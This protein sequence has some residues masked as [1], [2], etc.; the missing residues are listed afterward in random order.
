MTRYSNGELV[1]V[2]SL[3]KRLKTLFLK[4]PGFRRAFGTTPLSNSVEDHTAVTIYLSFITKEMGEDID[5][6]C[7]DFIN[8]CNRYTN[9]KDTRK[10]E[11]ISDFLDEST[12]LNETEARFRKDAVKMLHVAI[13]KLYGCI[14]AL[15][16]KIA[17]SE[18][19]E[20]VKNTNIGAKRIVDNLNRR[21]NHLNNIVRLMDIVEKRRDFLTKVISEEYG[22]IR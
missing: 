21:I 5:K 3:N 16:L 22:D 15:I 2:Q 17:C 4:N 1:L 20:H 12:G 14:D 8:I 10:A 19:K 7:N 11:I 18:I 6:I 13:F 9:I